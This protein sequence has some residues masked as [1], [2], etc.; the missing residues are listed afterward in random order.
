M[1]S[2]LDASSLVDSRDPQK[3][4]LPVSS[5]TESCEVRRDYQGLSLVK[6]LPSCQPATRSTF[7]SVCIIAAC[8]SSMMMNLALGQAVAISLPYA[9]KDLHIQKDDLQWIVNAYSISSVSISTSVSRLAR[10]T[11]HRH[12]SFFLAGGSQIFTAENLSGLLVILSWPHS[13][14]AQVS[15]IVR[16][17]RSY[18]T[19][20]ISM[21]VF[22]TGSWNNALY[23]T[24]DPRDRWSGCDSSLGKSHLEFPF[25]YYDVSSTY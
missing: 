14:S 8:T 15:Q 22:H 10:L 5:D 6:V 7:A 23:T 21:I 3:N 12:A 18:I 17:I 11:L 24:R 1:S 25:P 2:P 4:V 13:V 20:S 9:G 16:P 19:S